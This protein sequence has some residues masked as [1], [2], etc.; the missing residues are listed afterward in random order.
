MS[1]SAVTTFVGALR[2]GKRTIQRIGVTGGPGT[3]T[4]G[5][6]PPKAGRYVLSVRTAG[7]TRTLPIAVTK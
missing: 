1:A 2:Q 6:I 3:V 4:L 7:I 5:F